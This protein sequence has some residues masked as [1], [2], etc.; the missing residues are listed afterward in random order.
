VYNIAVANYVAQYLLRNI[1]LL[2]CAKRHGTNLIFYFLELCN[3]LYWYYLVCHKKPI[4]ITKDQRL[5]DG[6]KYGGFGL[7]PPY[8]QQRLQ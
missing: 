4:S 3:K 7:W 8:K 1:G 5:A 6:A 2:V